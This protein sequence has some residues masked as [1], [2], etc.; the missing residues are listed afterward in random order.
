MELKNPPLFI[1]WFF[2]EENLYSAGLNL[3]KDRL[4]GFAHITR[5]LLLP[6]FCGT[7][8]HFKLISIIQLG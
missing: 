2:E 5:F 3:K 6:C 7:Y 1:A 4:Q 8:T